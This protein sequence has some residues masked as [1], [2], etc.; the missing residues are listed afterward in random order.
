MELDV[1]TRHITHVPAV[2]PGRPPRLPA[3]RYAAVRVGENF[4]S[5]PER[6]FDA[7]LDP[8]IAGRWLFATALRPM[9]SVTIDARA[10]GAFRFVDRNDGG[11]L[12]HTGVYLEIVRPWRL[13]FTLSTG[14]GPAAVTRVVAEIVA[15]R[16]RKGGCELRLTHERV[17]GGIAGRV[18][19]RWI[20][21][22]YGLGVTLGR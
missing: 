15:S 3:R 11:Y 10:G 13:A 8:D 20:G 6:V 7:W 1:L 12:E 21:M 5:P 14:D 19:A 16:A 22:L 2:G 18:E 9:T 17:P 4:R